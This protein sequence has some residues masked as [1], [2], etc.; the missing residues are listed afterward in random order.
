MAKPPRLPA[1]PAA[2]WRWSWP[3]KIAI[4]VVV[5]APIGWLMF[6]DNAEKFPLIAASAFFWPFTFIFGLFF[7][8]ALARRRWYH[9]PPAAPGERSKFRL[10]VGS[11]L[12]FLIPGLILGALVSAIYAPTLA[13]IN[14][15]FAAEPDYEVWGFV[16]GTDAGGIKVSSPYFGA[17][18]ELTLRHR[19][20]LEGKPAAGNLIRLKLRR[21]ILLARYVTEFQYEKTR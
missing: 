9:P 13:T 3:L 21:G 2:K 4:A 11:L 7:T 10:V 14:G 18:R 6:R 17:A 5:W 12:L 16:I 15:M 1:R 8:W 20:F 19:R